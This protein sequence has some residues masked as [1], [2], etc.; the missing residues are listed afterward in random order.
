MKLS[1]VDFYLDWP[2]SIKITNLRGFIIGNLIKKG[3]VIRWSILDIKSSVD[4]PNTKKIRI[5][6]I[7]ANPTNS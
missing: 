1:R 7:L 4:Y 3:G 5:I 2:V 6:A